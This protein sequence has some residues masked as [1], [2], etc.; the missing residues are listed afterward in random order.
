[1]AW[2][3]FDLIADGIITIKNKVL[4]VDNDGF[5][6]F[7]GVRIGLDLPP[8]IEASLP[9]YTPNFSKSK[10]FEYTLNQDSIIL[11]PI[12][13]KKGRSGTIVI[14]QDSSGSHAVT[15]WNSDFIF[16]NGSPALNMNENAYNIFRYTVIENNRIL[17]EFISDFEQGG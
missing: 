2:K 13:Q 10:Y 5:L 6:L 14:R 7:D 1:M 12:G 3:V 11:S 17:I 16:T 15:E 4:D 8:I 9:E